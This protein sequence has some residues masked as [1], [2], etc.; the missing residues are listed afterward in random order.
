MRVQDIRRPE[1]PWYL[2]SFVLKAELEH[3]SEDQRIDYVRAAMAAAA[4]ERDTTV[5]VFD[6]LV[7]PLSEA[8]AERINRMV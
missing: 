1:G 4:I 3:M 5:L 8:E 6:V 2:V 7:T